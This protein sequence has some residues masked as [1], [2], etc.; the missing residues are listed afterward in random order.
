MLLSLGTL[1]GVSYLTNYLFDNGYVSE[2]MDYF[3][4]I[5]RQQKYRLKREKKQSNVLLNENYKSKEK[6]ANGN[7]KTGSATA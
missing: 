5:E 6:E 4:V 2:D 3:K 7:M 1:L